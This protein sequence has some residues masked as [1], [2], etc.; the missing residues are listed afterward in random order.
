ML[1]VFITPSSDK[2]SRLHNFL[3]N[4]SFYFVPREEIS[5][6]SAENVSV[7]LYCS[8]GGLYP[9]YVSEATTSEGETSF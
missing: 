5:T 2:L 8:K 6:F 7:R 4:R 3:S 1:C 9:V